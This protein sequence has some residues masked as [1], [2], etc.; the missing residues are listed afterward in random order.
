MSLLEIIY[1]Q[2]IYGLHTLAIPVENLFKINN[3]NTFVITKM[4]IFLLEML[5]QSQKI[6]TLILLSYYMV[7]MILK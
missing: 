6:T 5:R 1:L 7:I 2:K 3:G 4:R